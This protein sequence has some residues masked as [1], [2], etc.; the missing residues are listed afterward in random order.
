[1]KVVKYS[2]ILSILFVILISLS[3]LVWFKLN[4]NFLNNTIVNRE[5]TIEKGE[6]ISSIYNKI[7]QDINTPFGFRKYLDKV[8]KF[9][10]QIKFGYYVADNISLYDFIENIKNGTQSHIKVT[11]PEGYN[12]FDI[13]STLDKLQI[14]SKD[15]FLKDAFNKSI[16]KDVT[17][18]NLSTFEGFLYPAT[19]KFPKNY[20]NILILKTLYNGFLQNL[21]TNFEEKAKY[22]GLSLYEA[23][24]LASIVQKETY[25]EKEAPVVASV[26]HNRLK[27]NMRLQAD[28]TIIYGKYLS[29]DGN[30]RKNDIHDKSNIYNTYRH[31]GLPPTPISNPSIIALNAVINPAKT[32]YLY[33]VA[34]KKGNHIFSSDYRQHVNN[35]R[36]YQKR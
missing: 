11:I 32:N 9:G 24:T 4:S 19:Y 18:K 1:M 27:I 36:K 25:S 35:V 33:F 22:Y 5:I 3:I 16:I 31:N 28:P 17:G 34:D 8:L 14:T 20:D 23:V 26:F 7:F 21:P 2:I 29:F 6:S 10:S 13:A 15:S 30:I 12:V